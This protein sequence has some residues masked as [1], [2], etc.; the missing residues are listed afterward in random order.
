M[1]TD[2]IKFF[3]GYSAVFKNCLEGFAF[4]NFFGMMWDSSLPTIRIPSP[5]LVTSFSLSIEVKA[6]PFYYRDYFS[7]CNSRK[8]FSHDM[9]LYY[10]RYWYLETELPFTFSDNCRQK[11][12]MVFPALNMKPNHILNVINNLCIRF[13][14]CMASLKCQTFRKI[15]T[16]FTR[17]NHY[18]EKIYFF[19]NFVL[20][21]LDFLSIYSVIYQTK[22][23]KA[24]CDMLFQ[25]RLKSKVL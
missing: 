21:S 12:T 11:F 3:Y 19:H 16:L 20:Q 9:C 5:D 10:N 18:R 4:K 25:E 17:F 7:I 14:F 24:I 23:V 8:M 6:E 22:K 15:S 1:V 2:A 13:A